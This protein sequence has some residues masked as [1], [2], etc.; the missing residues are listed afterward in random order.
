MNPRI[1]MAATG[2]SL[3]LCSCSDAKKSE[4]E[5]TWTVVSA[6]KDPGMQRGPKKEQLA[7]AQ[8]IFT[9]D[10]YNLIIDGSRQMEG[11]FSLKS[12]G[13]PKEIDMVGG[14][15]PNL[16]VYK[17]AGDELTICFSPSPPGHRPLEFVVKPGSMRV[18][19][20]L[21]REHP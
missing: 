5:G 6:E 16:G 2:V 9:A 19:L 13:D 8:L 17:L 20:V 1:M 11:N 4:I 18:L 12:T 3:L 10:R 15:T 14:R 21:K 7:K